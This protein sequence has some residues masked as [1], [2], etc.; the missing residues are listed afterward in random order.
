MGVEIGAQMISIAASALCGLL[1][2]LLYDLLRVVRSGGGRALAAV[3]DLLFCLF[4]TG[5]MFLTGMVFCDGRPGLW[6]PVSFLAVFAL[7]LMGISPSAMLVPV[8]TL[9]SNIKNTTARAKTK[10]H[11]TQNAGAQRSGAFDAVDPCSTIDLDYGLLR[12]SV[13]SPQ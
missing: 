11:S 9:T 13:T 4:C 1:A 3:C 5:T 7:Y 6:E 8:S 12:R 2:G 10:T